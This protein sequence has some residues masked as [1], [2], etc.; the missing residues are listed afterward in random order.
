MCFCY[1]KISVIFS[2]LKINSFQL[3]LRRYYAL[4]EYYKCEGKYTDDIKALKDYSRDPFPIT[5]DADME[6]VLIGNGFDAS[7]SH[8]SYRATVNQDRYLVVSMQGGLSD[9]IRQLN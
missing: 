3:S 5:D 1:D 9:T 8:S 4:K 6:I 2:R 7:A